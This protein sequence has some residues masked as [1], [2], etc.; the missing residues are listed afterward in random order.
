MTGLRLEPPTNNELRHIAARL[1]HA[2]VAAVEPSSLV[3]KHLRLQADTT[4]VGTTHAPL[5]RWAGQTLVV[6]AGKAAAGM[7]AACEAVLGGRVRGEVVTAPGCGRQLAHIRVVEAGHPLPDP[8]GEQA[9]Q[10]MLDAVSQ[11]SEGGILCLISG[12]AS[13]VL[14]CPAPPLTLTDKIATTQA[15]L[16]CGADIHEL[17]TV[18]KHLSRIKGGRLLARA[19]LPVA[20]L[21][22]SD[23]IGDDPGVIG[24]GPTTADA[25]TYA[26]AY[27]V[28]SRYELF[29]KVPQA[30]LQHLQAGMA[31]HIA[32]T[33]KPGDPAVALGCSRVIGS[34]SVAVEGAAD[35]ARSLG[36]KVVV[37]RAPIEG[38]TTE[39]ARAFARRVL[40]CAE[41]DANVC[42]L[43]GGET[44]VRVRGAGRGGRNQEF[45]L[46]M[47]DSLA[48]SQALI[49]SAGTDGIDGPTAA[50]GAY[51]DGQSWQRA[52][53]RNLGP[54]DFLDRND[55]Y[56]FFQTVG[57]SFVSGPTGT[58]VM[59]LKIALLPKGQ[60]GETWPA[61]R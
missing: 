11:A 37:E 27:D 24:S 1:F 18:R 30:V 34:I 17:N 6:G 53:A 25:S 23:V 52:L 39:A 57:D 7:A 47:V 55:S 31:G 56:S 9:A 14:A 15:L 4:E 58:N 33:L 2:A 41:A 8:R 13:S 35:A 49:L 38:D 45:A 61:R 43:A 22:L 20:T 59:D 44:T 26:D 48:H 12:G 10:R 50:A 3:A 51:V 54:Q 36:W 21:I 32:E 19:R 46:A 28:L 5:T 29:A 60:P 42:V 40:A 16:A